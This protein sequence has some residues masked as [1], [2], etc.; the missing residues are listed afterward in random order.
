MT[1]SGRQYGN[2]PVRA[3]R[4]RVRTLVSYGIRSGTALFGIA[5]TLLILG[6]LVGLNDVITGLVLACII[7]GSI[8][9]A[10]ALVFHYG[11]KAADRED[12]AAGRQ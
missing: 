10:P 8:A 2:D 11:V 6:L 1:V 7:L 4:E 12:R 5:T 9:L 3:Q